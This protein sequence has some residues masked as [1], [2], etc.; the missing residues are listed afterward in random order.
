MAKRS[1]SIILAL[2]LLLSAFAFSGAAV[3]EEEPVTVVL[4]QDSDP[5]TLDPHRASGDQGG[6][7]YMNICETLTI[8]NGEWK[9][10]PLL[11]ESWEQESE[12]SWIF[13]LREGIE[14][15]NGEPFN[16]EAVVWN[17]DRGASK[18]YP[19]QAMEYITYY[20]HAEAIDDYTVR[21]VTN[22]YCG[23][24]PEYMSD[25]AMLAP[26]YS[27]E[28]GEEAIGQDII[29][30]GPYVLTS[31]EHDQQITLTAREDYWQGVPAVDVYVIRT[32]PEQATQLAELLSGNIDIALDVNFEYLD[33]LEGNDSVATQSRL[34]RRVLYIGFN[35]LDWCATEALK[36]K[37]VRQA[38]NY[39]VDVD[40]II[41][42]IMGGYGTRLESLWRH[43]FPGYEEG[44]VEGYTYDPDK[45]RELLAE[46]G[47]ADG[48]DVT[49]QV[50]TLSASKFSEIAQAVAYYLGEVGI[51]VTLEN[52]DTAT[53]RSITIEGQDQEKVSGLFTWSWASKPGL[54]DSWMTGI[55]MSDGMTSYNVIE[56]YDELCSEIL[57]LHDEEAKIPLYQELQQKLVD[58]PPFLYLFQQN[59]IYAV[60]SRLDWDVNS[61]CYILAFDMAVKA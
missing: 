22:Q 55:I 45:A 5:T 2:V 15:S 10:Q 50:N 35:T 12:T 4:A 33:M 29:G 46:A 20:D 36:D 39:A 34:E 48:F 58:D 24:I 44:L 14:F 16:A 41:E 54:C 37:R 26:A 31:W 28:I 13:H 51:N 57:A 17:L 47:Y 18:E 21:I 11:A 25:I 8:F 32:I 60:S 27:E 23:L 40:A 56:G 59:S 61:N 3:A 43:D 7:V 9:L 1:V 30:T 42:T 19:R 38:M 53:A 6:R 52:L 49:M